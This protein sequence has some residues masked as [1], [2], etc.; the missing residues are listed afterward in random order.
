MNPYK[1]YQ[2]QQ[3]QVGWTRIDMLLEL[4][5]GT[6]SKLEAAAAALARGD[7]AAAQ[8]L[9]A[10]GRLL[11]AALAAGVDPSYGESALNYQRLY[12]Y[13]LFNLQAGRAD[14]VEEALKVLRTL[15]EGFEGI[16]DEA[17]RLERSGEIPPLDSV[18]TLLLSA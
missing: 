1:A 7:A 14:K 2:Q 16:R 8:P 12:E 6:I 18:P 13:V 3:Q 9:L 10:K 11:V 17:L 15:R 4:F 5:D